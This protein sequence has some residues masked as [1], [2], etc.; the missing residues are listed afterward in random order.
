MYKNATE[1]LS[2][3]STTALPFGHLYPFQGY[4]PITRA[5]ALAPQWDTF[6]K[7]RG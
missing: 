5:Q 6:E 1:F 2:H 3:F 4:L 7:G